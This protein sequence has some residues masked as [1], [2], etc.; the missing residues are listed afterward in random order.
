MSSSQYCSISKNTLLTQ[1]VFKTLKCPPL[2]LMHACAP[3]SDCFIN[4]VLIHFVASCYIT[5]YC[6]VTQRK[7]T[8]INSAPFTQHYPCQVLAINVAK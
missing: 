4:N 8:W 3:L 6:V 7:V 5:G 1:C 2:A